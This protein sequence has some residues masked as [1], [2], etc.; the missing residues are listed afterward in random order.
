MFKKKSSLIL[1]SLALVMISFIITYFM[2]DHFVDVRLNG[3]DHIVIVYGEEFEDPQ[4][5]A[6]Y[7]GKIFSFGGE[8]LTF[9]VEGQVDTSKVGTYTLTYSAQKGSERKSIKRVVEVID[10][11]PPRIKL[12]YIDD[13]YTLPGH[14][15]KEEGFEAVDEYDGLI[16]DKVK[17]YFD[18][19]NV[20][21]YVRDNAGNVAIT[22]RTI[23]Y[24]DRTAPVIKLND[25]EEVT[26]FV[27]SEYVDSFQAIDDCLGDVTDRVVVTGK[28]DTNTIGEYELSY[29]VSDDYN[30]EATAKRIVKV[31]KMQNVSGVR[32]DGKTIYLTFDDGPSFHTNE[33]LAVLDK[34]N[35]KATF[36]T[37]GTTGYTNLIAEEAKRGHCVAVHTYT[38]EY[39][40]IYASSDAYW[41]DF[42][43]QQQ[44]IENLTGQTTNLFRFPGGSS[45]TISAN[46]SKGIMSK[47]VKQAQQKGLVYFDWNVSS[48]DAGETRDTEQ[49]Y[50]NV[51]EGIKRNS[52]YGNPSIVLQHDI[53]DYSVKAVEKIIQW[54]L[55]NG[56]HFEK[57]SNKSSTAHHGV[58]N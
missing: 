44:I 13:Y 47:L 28:V 43:R 30:N 36:F 54:A 33:L 56:Y 53:H 31:V 52:S 57:L 38:H 58:N 17:S 42:Y 20:Y 1:C 2:Q 4:A 18:N 55:S 34:Y 7:R 35:V 45:N 10:N 8:E 29:K 6:F 49:V 25:G 23:V 32:E 39:S 50:K 15:Y 48:G 3:S 51:I 24:D 26:I 22:K 14:E 16:N 37:I 21:Y 12:K 11:K 46:Y 27:G 9:K 19:G 5:S 41:R 40:Q